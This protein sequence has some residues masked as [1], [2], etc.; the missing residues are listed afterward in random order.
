[1]TCLTGLLHVR[2][3]NNIGKASK[4]KRRTEKKL[5]LAVCAPTVL[6]VLTIT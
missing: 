3:V 6:Y 2:P 1:M 5:A 4:K